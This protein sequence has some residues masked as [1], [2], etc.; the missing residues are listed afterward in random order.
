MIVEAIH[1]SRKIEFEYEKDNNGRIIPKKLV[2][3]KKDERLGLIEVILER[4]KATIKS[5]S[6]IFEIENDY[7]PWFD[8]L[9]SHE[10]I[11]SEWY[12]QREINHMLYYFIHIVPELAEEIGDKLQ[13]GDN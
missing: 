11:V 12:L 7:S 10:T 8:S 2:I 13:R 6:L 1:G 3:R 4:G 9:V 5:D